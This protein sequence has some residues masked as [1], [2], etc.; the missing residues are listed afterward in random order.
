MDTAQNKWENWPA[1]RLC[2]RLLLPA[3]NQLEEQIEAFRN[4]HPQEGFYPCPELSL[5]S[6]SFPERSE[7]LMLKWLGNYLGSVPGGEVTI[8]HFS[9]IPPH[10]VYARVQPSPNLAN[11]SQGL[12][13][14]MALASGIPSLADHKSGYH[15][16]P[17][18]T[19]LPGTTFHQAMQFFSQKEC[20]ETYRLQEL[21]VRKKQQGGK[22]QVLQ[23]FLLN[24]SS[25]FLQPVISPINENAA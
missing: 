2:A 24:H 22:W 5:F 18:I 6:G 9:G 21:L 16:I 12:L 25:P 20:H 10:V 23:H 19:D 8:N 15:K 7:N 4:R 14:L 17:L 11:F 13:E 3:D 1:Y